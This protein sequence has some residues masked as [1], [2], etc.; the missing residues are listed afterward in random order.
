M[1]EKT[2]QETEILL[3]TTPDSRVKID[4]LYQGETIWIT[5]KRMAE[6]FGV[7]RPAVTK[8]LS[9]IFESGELIE[10]SVCSILEHTAADGKKYEAQYYNLDAVIAVGY[11]VNS[12]QATQFRI[13]AT[14]VLK[15]Y[16]IKGFALDTERLKNGAKFG[17][18]Y[19]DELLEKIREI[20]ASER[21]FYQKITDIY[22]QCSADYDPHAE[23]TQTFYATA[24]NKLHW[25]IHQQTAAEVITNRADKNKPH[26]G[27]NTWKN[28]PMGKVLK[29]D[30]AIA[31][32]YLSEAELSELNH[33]VTM[34]LDYAE[35][36]AKRHQ[37]MKM[38]DWAEKLDAFLAFNGYPI[39]DNAGRVSA[40]AAKEQ[41]EREY[42]AFRV[43]Q[44]KKYLSDFDRL[45]ER[46]Q[47]A[48]VKE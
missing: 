19:F 13:W 18:D 40:E 29:S 46:A 4:V 36:Q 41:V 5:Q 17:Q 21:R 39:L 3:Y 8:H 44:D 43:G 26:M 45:V 24:Q 38:K 15:E 7:Q 6:L 28:A 14:Q 11:R 48:K 22:A 12:K 25:A 35:L 20:R 42:E 23:T 16:I 27:L 1:I 31:K 47:G 2:I 30:I 34:Y 32:N 37:L 33:V 10:K 9:N